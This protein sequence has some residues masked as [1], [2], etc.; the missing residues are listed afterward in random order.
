MYQRA[1]VV[2]V[3]E[4][5]SSVIHVL[6]RQ[7]DPLALTL[8]PHITVVFPFESDLSADELA[9]HMRRSLAG[10]EPFTVELRGI[11]G[12]EGEYLFLNVK[13]GNDE[14]IALH[15]RL[16]TGPLQPNLST[17]HPYVPHITVGRLDNAEAFEAALAEVSALD[18]RLTT[19]VREVTLYRIGDDGGRGVERRVRLPVE[20]V[21][22]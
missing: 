5:P 13:R 18:G 6:R 4:P 9:A 8:A 2:F 1:S 14:L 12:S 20:D 16:Y 15:D 19:D 7:Y 17:H 11:T 22:G 3:V 10:V 21:A